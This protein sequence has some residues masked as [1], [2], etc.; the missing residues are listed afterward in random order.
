LLYKDI[1]SNVSLATV[2]RGSTATPP[3]A[4]GSQA[5]AQCGLV[6]RKW[7]GG[8]MGGGQ[9]PVNAG[10]WSAEVPRYVGWLGALVVG[11]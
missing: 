9:M 5:E 4:A 8:D 3:A 7:N 2:G 11:L 1:F 10:G 6:T